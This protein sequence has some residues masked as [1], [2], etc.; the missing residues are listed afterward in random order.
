MYSLC[1][2]GHA[3]T[4]THSYTHTPRSVKDVL[5]FTC[6]TIIALT[7][8]IESHE[9]K[10]IEYAGSCLP[11][12]HPCASS[13]DDVECLLSD[14]VGKHFAVRMVRYNWSNEYLKRLDPELRFFSEHDRFYGSSF[15]ICVNSKRNPRKQQVQQKDLLSQLVYGR[16]TLP[17][18]GARSIRMEYHNAH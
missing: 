14:L 10:Q 1:T 4:H 5:G 15:D 9:W 6:E 2:C 7:T 12:K 13:T 18:P 16:V 3:C 8:N 11:Q 17:T